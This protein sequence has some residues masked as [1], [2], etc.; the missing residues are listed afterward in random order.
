MKKMF[1]TLA[2]LLPAMTFAQDANAL[3]SK[4]SER[5]QKTKNLSVAFE[6]T[7]ASQSEKGTLLLMDKMYKLDLD[8][9]TIYFNG[10][11]RWT[12]LKAANEV[13]ISLPNFLTDGIFANPTALFVFNKEE[14]NSK[15][16]SEKT[17][18]G[19]T[20]VEVDLFPKDEQAP[21]TNI[22]LRM[23]KSTLQPV[24]IAYYSKDGN[25][26]AIAITAFNISVKPT[27]AD[28][29]FDTKKHPN[30]E[31]VDMR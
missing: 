3:L 18:N 2:V 22:N 4:F 17:V 28:F 21:F 16:G 25:N 31:V 12:Y 10:E 19:K 8:A 1:F 24:S 27:P 14:Y 20:V 30:V 13:T 26:I 15:L 11:V 23:D 9:S 7:F 6:Y 29:T 5:M